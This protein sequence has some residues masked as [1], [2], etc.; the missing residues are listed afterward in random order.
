MALVATSQQFLGFAWE[1]KYYVFTVL[2]FGLSTACYVFTK[3]LRPLVKLWRGSGIRCVVYIDDGLIMA[4][5][6]ERALKDSNFVRDSLESAGLVINIEKSNWMPQ[7]RGRWLGFELDLAQ[8]SILVPPQKVDSLRQSLQQCVSAQIIPART[9]ASL[10][11]K[12]ISMSFAL[13]PIARLRTRSMYGLLNSRLS[14]YDTLV[15]NGET[16]GELAFW[17]S[18]I[19]CFNGQKLWKSPSAVRIVYSDASG[20]GYAGYTVQHGSH[21]AHG[22][23]TEIEKAKSS[24][25]R[26]LAAVSRVLAAVSKLLRDNK[27][28]W[29]TDNQ[30]VVQIIKLGSRKDEL[31][32]LALNIFR[33]SMSNNITL[34]FEPEWIPR[35]ENQIADEL[36]RVVDYD[37]WGLNSKV[38]AWLDSLWGP[39]TVDRFAS[40]HN[41]QLCWYNSRFCE[42][43]TEAVDAFTVNW[44]GENNW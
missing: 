8:G 40:S 33:T 14:W 27:V 17:N 22:L 10:I 34:E 42:E 3:L 41:T 23:W 13:G 39:H 24:T 7:Q 38:F 2:P 19:D 1:D 30:N 32:Q 6:F 18:C 20:T 36:S 4:S 29:F 9:L 44:A 15:I 25:W 16:R 5:G 21:I 11:G 28:K 35:N 26:E 12:I 43:G 37:D 31:Q